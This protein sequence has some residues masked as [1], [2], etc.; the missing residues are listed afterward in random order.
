M[1]YVHFHAITW[2]IPSPLELD[3]V[4][5]S[6]DYEPAESTSGLVRRQLELARANL[7]SAELPD[8]RVAE[9]VPSLLW[10]EL[11]NRVSHWFGQS[12]HAGRGGNRTVTPPD[13]HFLRDEDGR[14]PVHGGVETFKTTRTGATCSCSTSTSRAITVRVWGQPPDGLDRIG[15]DLFQETAEQLE[16][17]KQ[18][19]VQTTHQG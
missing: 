11:Q 7:V 2:S 9:N 5:H 6:V 18:A 19:G 16:Q 3:G 12:A 15:G 4:S 8:Y 14:R 13:E 10:G 17:H 1:A